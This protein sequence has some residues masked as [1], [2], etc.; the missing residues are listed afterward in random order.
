MINNFDDQLVL[1]RKRLTTK[2][3]QKLL[4]KTQGG[5]AATQRRKATLFDG[6]PDDMKALLSE[7]ARTSNPQVLSQTVRLHQYLEA[8]EEEFAWWAFRA[9]LQLVLGYDVPNKTLRRFYEDEE[10][11]DASPST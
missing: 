1:F 7:H 11:V 6:L 5:L 4:E 8:R 2:T 9:A 10:E 3:I